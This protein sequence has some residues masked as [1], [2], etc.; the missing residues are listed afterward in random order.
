MGDVASLGLDSRLFANVP[1]DQ[2]YLKAQ[3]VLYEE[4]REAEKQIIFNQ[5][6]AQDNNGYSKNKSAKLAAIISKQRFIV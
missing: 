1:T 4:K 6:T 5:L 2:D 3:R